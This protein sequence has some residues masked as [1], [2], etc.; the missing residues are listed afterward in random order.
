M[1]SEAEEERLRAEQT[2]QVE[3][4]VRDYLDRP[5]P[6]ES[7]FDYLFAQL[8]TALEEQ[9]DSLLGGHGA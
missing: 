8:P 5:L 4:A 9:R 3:Q 1:W 6:P 7:M 2:A